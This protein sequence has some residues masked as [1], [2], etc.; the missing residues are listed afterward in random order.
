MNRSAMCMWKKTELYPLDLSN[1][2]NS[3]KRT[4]R[5]ERFIISKNDNLLLPST[6]K[7]FITFNDVFYISKT[8]ELLNVKHKDV[9]L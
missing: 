2:C 4:L 3:E 1:G 9:E 5:E 7:M 6:L 8:S